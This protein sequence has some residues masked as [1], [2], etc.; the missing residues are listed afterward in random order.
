[1]LG[2]TACAA[3]PA[4]QGPLAVT[5]LAAEAHCRTAQKAPGLSWVTGAEGLRDWWQRLG[6]RTVGGTPASPPAVDFDRQRVL[7]VDMG[8]RP[9]AGYSVA[10]ARP[11]AE[12][13]DGRLAIRVAWREPGPDTA[14]AQVT[15]H[16]CLLL[17]LPAGPY[18]EVAVIDR[19]GRLRG[20]LAVPAP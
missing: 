4:G 5:T 16:P 7:V 2:L 6:P 12:L 20:K 15:T 19:E 13:A 8:S 1:L 3:V 11:R 14:V 10:L 17:R 18:R 9:T